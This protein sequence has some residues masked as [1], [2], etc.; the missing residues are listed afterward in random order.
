VAVDE[1]QAYL[2]MVERE[3]FWLRE[4]L[5]LIRFLKRGGTG[6]GE[7]RKQRDGE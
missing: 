6:W 4:E 3:Q 5:F 2:A 1:G 7:C